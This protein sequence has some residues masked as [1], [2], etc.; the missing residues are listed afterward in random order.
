LAAVLRGGECWL[1]LC[2][3]ECGKDQRK[4]NEY[5]EQ[6]L[7]VIGHCDSSIIVVATS[8]KPNPVIALLS[9]STIY[10]RLLEQSWIRETCDEHC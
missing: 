9:K 8:K 7:D 4:E 6:W 10:I 3:N 1:R 5:S 2:H